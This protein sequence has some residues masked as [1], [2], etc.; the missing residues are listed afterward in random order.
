[1]PELLTQGEIE[2]QILSISNELADETDRYRDLTE[3]AAGAEADFKYRFHRR[4]IES[5]ARN[6]PMPRGERL[7]VGELEADAHV[8]A[9]EAFQVWRI[10][11]ARCDSSKQA[12]LSLRSRLD[13]LRTLAANIRAQT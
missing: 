6:R 2:R 4:L 10:F 12:L 5:A 11:D 9:T 7:T 1:M 3:Q 13:A 8:Y